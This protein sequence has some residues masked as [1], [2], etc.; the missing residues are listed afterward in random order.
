MTDD[1]LISKVN[2]YVSSDIKVD[3]ILIFLF[4]VTK[5][6]PLYQVTVGS[7]FALHLH[8]IVISVP[9]SFGIIRGFSIN[10]GANPLASLA[11]IYD[12]V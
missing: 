10:D 11:P 4:S 3:F 5:S 12:V 7:G 9:E 6:C 2:S 8:F 1:T